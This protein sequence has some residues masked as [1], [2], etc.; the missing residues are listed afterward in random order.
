MRRAILAS[1]IAAFLL[2]SVSLAQTAPKK[3]KK[4][5]AAEK[6]RAAGADS[7]S[8]K[9]LEGFDQFVA[10]ALKDWKVPG[11][12]VAVIQGGQVV[13][14]K[15]Y[16]YRDVEKQ[17]P[18]TPQTLFM[19]GSITKSFTVTTL[20]M[21]IDEGKLEWDEPVRVAF[22]GFK[23]YDPILTEQITIRDLV[24]HRS[25][26]PR[27]DAVWY[28]SDFSREDLIRRLQYLEP[29]KPLRSTFQ[30]NNLMF[31]TAGFIAGN[32]NGAPW[33]DTVRH[34]ILEPLG[35]N[36]TTFSI[37]AS[38]KT[39]DFAQPYRKDDDVKSEVR[40]IPFDPQCPDTCALGPAGELNSNTEDMSKYLLFHMGKGKVA[41]KQLL[42]ENNSI[43]MQTPQ[44]TISGAPEYPENGETSYGMGFFISTYRG[45]KQVEHGG[46]L[47][48]F[49][50][51][52]TFLPA[53]QI[54]VVVLSNLDGTGL[55]GVIANNVFDRLLGL[56]EVPWSK[57][58]LETEVKGKESVAEAKNKGYSPH[59]TGT[60]PSH[61]LKDF[62]GEYSHPGYGI[63][64]ISPEGEGLKLAL[65][66]VT[67]H[68]KHYHYDV[69]EV[70]D[71]PKDPFAKQK[72]MFLTDLHGEISSLSMPLEPNVKDIVFTRMPDRQL[73]DR[74]YVQAFTGQYEVPG[75]PTPFTVSLHGD[76]T[77]FLSQPGDEDLELLPTK[78]NTFDLKGLAGFSV[79]FKKDAAGKIAEAVLYQPD[80]AIILKRK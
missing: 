20:G 31:M 57:R 44:M 2:S 49:S 45:H 10:Q 32:L 73:T 69:F 15:G 77:L 76:H 67:M 61:E 30:Y 62:A 34:R 55:P 52:F 37:L 43:Q 58:Y 11:V 40:R 21:L 41:G 47:D 14:L 59:K 16:G 74:N 42:S 65:N 63:V 64:A 25:G 56:S 66:K 68:A 51:E 24:T 6:K 48:G 28:T 7:G 50:A 70:P 9:E 4:D 27:H 71:D 46:N 75:S 72:V 5:A 29:N 1:V 36:G 79:E 26:L 35:M 19:I 53:D 80:N 60:H 17:L 33:E 12:G 54:G 39:P 23:L 22:P 38:Q 18:V 13:L 8:A 78:N 3:S